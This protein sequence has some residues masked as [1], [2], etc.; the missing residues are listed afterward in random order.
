MTPP[1]LATSLGPLR[2]PSPFVLASGILGTYEASLL[3]VAAAGAGALTTKSCSL[4]PRAGHPTPCVLPWRGGFINAVGLSNPGVAEEAKVVRA[5]KEACSTPLIASVFG[6]T[7]DE[8]AALAS[9]MADAG[10]DAVELNVSCPNVQSE[11]GTPF[12]ADAAALKRV[13]AAAKKALDKTGTPLAVKLSL[14]CAS[15]GEMARVVEGEGADWVVAIN[16]VGPGMVIDPVTGRPVLSNKRGGVSGTA[17]LPLA[18]RAVY[19]IREAC[20]RLPILATGGTSRLEDALQHFAAGAGAVA[21]GSAVADEGPAIFGRLAKE[22]AGELSRRGLDS[23]ASL[24]GRAH[25]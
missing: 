7:P 13:T 24:I 23:I 11:F 25:A 6:A 16:T 21:I 12:A 18:V 3:R 1:S 2:L 5:V 8:F 9:A 20:P 15:I 14:Q 22:L 19:D 10:A 4:A 17:I